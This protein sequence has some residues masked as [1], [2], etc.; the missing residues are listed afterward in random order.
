MGK[1]S[2]KE[3]IKGKTNPWRIK[4]FICGKSGIVHGLLLYQGSTTQ[5]DENC[6]K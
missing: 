4:M 1:F 2:A 5:L 6:C 3:Y